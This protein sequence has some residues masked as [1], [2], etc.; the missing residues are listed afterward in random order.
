[1]N[2]SLVLALITILALQHSSTIF[3]PISISYEPVQAAPRMIREGEESGSSLS[4]ELA[5]V[6]V[7]LNDLAQRSRII[8][9]W[10]IENQTFSWERMRITPG[11]DTDLLEARFHVANAEAFSAALGDMKRAKSELDEADGYL[12]N[13]LRTAASDLQPFIRAIHDELTDA[14]SEVETGDPD[15]DVTDDQIKTDLDWVVQTLHDARR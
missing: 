11:V 8:R 7:Y 5:T 12:Q 1:M 13:A 10:F 2:L 6:I 15:T 14:K 9:D 3:A 4:S